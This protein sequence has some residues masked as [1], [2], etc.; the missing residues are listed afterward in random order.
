M[1]RRRYRFLVH[2]GVFFWE[3]MVPGPYSLGLIRQARSVAAAMVDESADAF[4]NL[5]MGLALPQEGLQA[6]GANRVDGDWAGDI[7]RRHSMMGQEPLEV[8]GDAFVPGRDV[9][10]ERFEGPALSWDVAAGVAAAATSVLVDAGRPNRSPAA[11]V[12]RT[13]RG[14]GAAHGP[15]PARRAVGADGAAASRAVILSFVH[16]ASRAVVSVFLPIIIVPVG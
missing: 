13:A 14:L 8:A 11:T 9:G 1:S 2:H 12:R 4:P 3:T 7:G 15:G 10:Y 6:G 16:N 5:M